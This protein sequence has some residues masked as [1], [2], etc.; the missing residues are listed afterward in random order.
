MEHENVE[1]V[2][3][4]N[5]RRGRPRNRRT[6]EEEREFRERQRVLRNER[7]R[8][9]RAQRNN[10]IN[11]NSNT[12]KPNNNTVE[13]DNVEQVIDENRRRGRPRIIRTSEEER[14]FRERQ[15]VLRNDR[16]RRLK[17]RCSNNVNK[18]SNTLETNN[19]QVNLTERSRQCRRSCHSRENDEEEIELQNR[20]RERNV[21]NQRF[22]EQNSNVDEYY[23]G[24]M[25]VL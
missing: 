20:G 15:R 9:H 7:V 8:R 2:I 22:L 3:D 6:S 13:H 23:L 1:Q 11:N 21:E 5:C 4:E 10:N 16:V 12:L 17:K 24:E 19:N 14:E 25:D 18:N